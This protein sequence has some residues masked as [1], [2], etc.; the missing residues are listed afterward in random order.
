[1]KLPTDLNGRTI[2]PDLTTYSVELTT[3][4]LTRA[5]ADLSANERPLSP[6]GILQNRLAGEQGTS[7]RPWISRGVE[8]GTPSLTRKGALV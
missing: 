2:D 1:M 3:K 5:R 7:R 8:Q 4:V 6:I